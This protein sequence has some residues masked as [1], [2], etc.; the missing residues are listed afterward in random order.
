MVGDRQ[1]GKTAACLRIAEL[2]RARGLTVAGI[3]APAVY[4]AGTLEGYDALDLAR[5]RR[6]PLARTVGPGVESVGGFFFLAEGLR[7]GREVLAHAA[8]LPDALV[9]VDEVGPLELA[10][11]GWAGHLEPLARRHAVSVF[12]VRR[13]LLR[14]LAERWQVPPAAVHDVACGV[15]TVAGAVLAALRT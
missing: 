11:G 8:T 15:D 4:A 6:A 9:I 12:T 10:G 1:S 2:G 3:A 5:G 13:G 14:Q 7:L